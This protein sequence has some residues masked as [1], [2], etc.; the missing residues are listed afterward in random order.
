MKVA[1]GALA[2]RLA[3]GALQARREAMRA[4]VLTRFGA[5][6]ADLEARIVQAD[7]SELIQLHQRAILVAQIE[8]LNS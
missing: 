2:E 6:P 7:E 4:V 1:H 5:V 8:D 3:E